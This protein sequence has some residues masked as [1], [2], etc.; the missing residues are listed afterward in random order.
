M[1]LMIDV[2]RAA[3]LCFGTDSSGAR[4]T[5]RNLADATE[6]AASLCGLLQAAVSLSVTEPGLTNHY[7]E[8]CCELLRCAIQKLTE[9]DG[10]RVPAMWQLCAALAGVLQPLNSTSDLT[11]R[12]GLLLQHAQRLCGSAA[13]LATAMDTVRAQRLPPP[14]QPKDSMEEAGQAALA[15]RSP[16]AQPQALAATGTSTCQPHPP[17]PLSMLVSQLRAQRQAGGPTAAAPDAPAVRLAAVEAVGLA[18]TP[19]LDLASA[20]ALAPSQGP[21]PAPAP[22]A[23]AAPVSLS[24]PVWSGADTNLRQQL[25]QWLVGEGQAVGLLLQ[26]ARQALQAAGAGAA[27]ARPELQQAGA[28]GDG[29]AQPVQLAVL[30]LC[31]L[32]RLLAWLQGEGWG[33]REGP[34]DQDMADPDQPG[35][36]PDQAIDYP[37]DQVAQKLVTPRS[38]QQQQ[39]VESARAVLQAVPSLLDSLVHVPM[40]ELL[41][42]CWLPPTSPPAP[43]ALPALSPAP[44]PLAIAITGTILAPTTVAAAPL[45]S[46]SPQPGVS[47]VLLQLWRLLRLLPLPAAQLDQARL[48]LLQ[49]LCPD[50]PEPPSAAV[51]AVGVVSGG[52]GSAAGPQ[53]ALGV[54]V[55]VEGAGATGAGASGARASRT[56][57]GAGAAPGLPRPDSSSSGSSSSS[58]EAAASPAL[59]SPAPAPATPLLLAPGCPEP[60]MGAAAQAGRGQLSGSWAWHLLQLWPAQDLVRLVARNPSWGSRLL[61][62]LAGCQGQGQQGPQGQGP[63]GQGGA[64]GEVLGQQMLLQLSC[65]LVTALRAQGRGQAAR[66]VSATESEVVAGGVGSALATGPQ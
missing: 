49:A 3:A 53:P 41:L 21:G 43:A 22:A 10:A 24:A 60:V 44:P 23:A 50:A 30:A 59:S 51:A 46:L 2:L 26:V 62:K 19:N 8:A 11:A 33:D 29:T 57:A 40:Q 45:T 28:A 27:A 15:A 58:S 63:Q 65:C 48:Q 61:D 7:R 6:V 34:A 14:P 54:G 66:R 36:Q 38:E 55:A 42:P 9:A 32:D 12:Q 31:S 64:A 5:S 17:G 47:S 13:A 20:P 37:P 39:W 18:A 52:V 56:G 4:S 35:Q 1:L 16:A 25:L